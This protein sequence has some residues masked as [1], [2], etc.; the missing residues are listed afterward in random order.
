MSDNDYIDK[1][2]IWAIDILVNNITNFENLMLK[3]GADVLLSTPQFVSALNDYK[4]AIEVLQITRS[5]F[6][7]P[8]VQ[9]KID[10]IIDRAISLFRELQIQSQKGE[11]VELSREEKEELALGHMGGTIYATTDEELK[12]CRNLVKK[13]YLKEHEQPK[14]SFSH[15]FG[16]TSK[17][18]EVA[19]QAYNELVKQDES[20]LATSLKQ[21]QDIILPKIYE[22]RK[23]RFLRWGDRPAYDREYIDRTSSR[24]EN[25][26]LSLSAY[27]DELLNLAL[28]DRL[29]LKDYD[30]FIQLYEDLMAK[31]NT[32]L[33]QMQK[34]EETKHEEKVYNFWND[35][36]A[37]VDEMP[38][39]ETTT[40]Y[41]AIKTRKTGDTI[42]ILDQ[43]DLFDYGIETINELT[44]DTIKFIVDDFLWHTGFIKHEQFQGPEYDWVLYSGQPS[45]A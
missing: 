9:S 21:A 17:G 36:V 4:E 45:H 8:T 28:E 16:L 15:T 14:H 31:A 19:K 38:V 33:M 13:G 39:G 32:L 25:K 40:F 44:P 1:K 41:L 7:N 11:E 30:E 22:L 18:K 35:F 12:L 37:V 42:G 10:E 29:T 43:Q 5:Q 20:E 3:Y 2:L 24:L 26:L 6:D 23:F 27:C 34:G